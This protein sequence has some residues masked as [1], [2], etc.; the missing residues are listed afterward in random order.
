MNTVGEVG[1]NLTDTW[2]MSLVGPGKRS[3][4][5]STN[6]WLSRSGNNRFH[7][8]NRESL[9]RRRPKDIG[10][11]P[12]CV[13]GSRTEKDPRR[14]D[15]GSTGQFNTNLWVSLGRGCSG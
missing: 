4:V 6:K 11:H 13:T 10:T 12:K 3:V 7:L 1:L 8:E 9:V 14:G 15:N 2:S 5:V